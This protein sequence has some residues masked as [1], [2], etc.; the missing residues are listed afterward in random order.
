MKILRTP[1]SA[2]INIIDF[3]FKENYHTTSDGLRVH[4]LDEGNKKHPVVL[5]LHGEPSWSFLYRSMIPKLIA[6]GLRVVAPDLVGFGK[7]DK[8]AAQS[9]YTYAKHIDWMQEVLDHL[10][11]KNI[12]MFIQDW[13]GLIGLRLLTS[14]PDNFATVVAANT[15]LPTGSVTPPKAFLDWQN[16]AATSPKFDVATV[17]QMATTTTLSEDIVA[18]YNAPFPTE[19]HKAGARVF[20]ALVPT[21]ENDPES[22]N[23]KKAWGVLTQW[24]KPF[25][26]L[27][28]DQ[29]P[30]T[31]GGDQ[32]FQKLVP[33]TKDQDHQTISG[34]HF[35]QEDSG[36]EIATLMVQFYSKNKVI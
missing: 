24:I 2:F 32:V 25:L 34:G 36:P 20:P 19:E 12:N 33:G 21:T 22:E 30:I 3:P 14:N 1:E 11:L 15:M 23:N 8:P 31:K 9:D 6:A 5:L 29:D 28:S 7:S 27:F 10:E 35:L 16:F 26:C 17:L 13:G 18:A 4:Y